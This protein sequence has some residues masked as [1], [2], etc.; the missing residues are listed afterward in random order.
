MQNMDVDKDDKNIRD[1]EDR[2]KGYA[3]ADDDG[4]FVIPDIT[5]D[6]RRD[7]IWQYLR[8]GFALM[9]LVGLRIAICVALGVFLG[10]MLDKYLGTSPIFI[11]ALSLLGAGAAFKLIYDGIK[12]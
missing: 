12:T 7:V 6:N 4:K 5:K 3:Y 1:E 10:R 8:K 11:I 2:S 9:T